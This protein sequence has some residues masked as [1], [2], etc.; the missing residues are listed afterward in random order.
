MIVAVVALLVAS[1]AA[2]PASAQETETEIYPLVFPVAGEHY[3]SD[4]WGA[5]RSSGRTH[6]G[7]DIMTWGVK[8]VPV[9]AA[10][11][12]VV[13]W[14]H[15]EVG[16]RCCAMELI[17]DDGWRSWYIHLNNDTQL[18]DGTYT[19]DGLGW[20]FAP[21]IEPGAR[22]LA[23]QVIGFVGD[24]GNAEGVAPHLHFELH[25]PDRVKTNPY[26]HLV[27]AQDVYTPPFR[28]DDGSVHE[29]NIAFIYERGITTGCEDEYY[30]PSDQ[31]T[32]GQ[33]AAFL[34]RALALVPA[35]ENPFS[36]VVGGVFV[37]NIVA[38]YEAGITLGCTE[39]E[40][41]PEDPVSRAQ[42]A[43]FLDRAFGLPETDQVGVF[44]D[45][46][47]VHAEAI[48]RLAAAGITT[49]CTETEYCPDDAVTRAQ[50]ASFIARAIQLL[51]S[52]PA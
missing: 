32:R 10:A 5:A 39:G 34:A 43:S 6:E 1:A 21:G 23:G 33:M 19:D 27:A 38:I 3:Y 45:A 26:P 28:D 31:V 29:P 16:V 25:R 36:D 51:E 41:C 47:G 35:G 13:G 9:V 22:V 7:T 40:Y 37:D 14:M 8:G 44:S 52:P 15:A 49:G 42:M 17:H 30:C 46:A 24:S 18:E 11:D 20:G 50:M 4:T 48:D 2:P 12:G